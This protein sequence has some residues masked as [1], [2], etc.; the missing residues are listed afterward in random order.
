MRQKRS[1]P[2]LRA[3][4]FAALAATALQ[5][6]ACMCDE[7]LNEVE[8]GFT[9]EPS[10]PNDVID[11]GEV[12]VGRER[13]R[14][15]RITNT[16]TVALTEFE[17]T[18]SERNATH[19][20]VTFPADFG[21][22]LNTS[23]ALS[24]VFAP[25]AESTNLG[26]SFTVA[27]P[28]VSGVS[29]GAYNVVVDGDGYAALTEDDAGV[30]DGG[31][32]DG[33]V[34]A[35]EDGGA[36][37]GGDGDGG[38]FIDAG[39]VTP[40]D[41]GVILGPN[42]EWEAKGALQEPRA[43]F[44]SV[45]LDDGSILSIGGFGA[46]GDARASIERFDPSTGLSL[47]VGHMVVPRVW[48]GAALMPSGKVA[49]VGGR[50]ALVD[51]IDLSTVEVFDP[52]NTDVATS[53]T[54]V[55]GQGECQLDDVIAGDGLLD[56][57]RTDPL[58]VAST[59]E[60]AVFVIFGRAVAF[61]METVVPEHFVVTLSDTPSAVSLGI[62]PTAR[63]G[64]A[65]I[66]LEDGRVVVAGGQDATGALFD[67]AW[68]IDPDAETV[69]DLGITVTPRTMGGGAALSTGDV[70]LVGGTGTNGALLTQVERIV[71]V[72]GTPAVEVLANPIVAGRI[73]PT[74]VALADDI[75]LV[76]GG[77]ASLPADA[78]D[79]VV[80][81]V[82]ADVLVPL[83]SGT[84]L[85]LSSSNQ[86]ATP[87]FMHQ[88]IASEDGARATF[89]GGTPTV[90]RMGAH[91]AIEH[92]DVVQNAFDGAGLLGPGS[93]YEVAAW[94]PGGGVLS[95]GGTDPHTGAITARNRLYDADADLHVELSPLGGPRRDHTVTRLGDDVVYLVAGG[96]DA[97]GQVLSSASLYVPLSADFDVALPVSLVRARAEHTST[98][99]DDGRVLLCGGKG[100]LGEPLDTCEIFTPP[101]ALQNPATYDTASFELVA[102][103]MSAG[104]YAHTSTLLDTGE[105]LLVGGGDVEVDLVRADL[106]DPT[107]TR[108]LETGVP[109][110]ARR[111]HAAIF[112]GSGR[113]LIVGGEVGIGGLGPTLTTEVY[114]RANGIFIPSG[115]MA[116]ARTG[117]AG[118]RLLDGQVLVVGGATFGSGAFPTQSLLLAELYTPDAFGTGT[119]ENIDIPLNT[120]R[121]DIVGLDVYG[122]AVVVA[123]TRR[124][125]VLS[126]GAERRTPLF[127]VERLMNPDP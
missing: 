21:I 14:T 59:S 99:L 116:T 22:D 58:V 16:G 76:A 60:D 96:R 88:T 70:L 33:G 4:L 73:G 29:C 45:L 122:R 89:I 41:A 87:R 44:A 49:I 31:D 55:S 40:P 105:V 54:C 36:P 62:G 90:P 100:A 124:D 26:S 106:F 109:T 93:A 82:S 103:R 118:F 43:G 20:R 98:L 9:V 126:S 50:S 37:D 48:P 104:R 79:G 56:S 63:T 66:P 102:G 1:M 117:A 67:D 111:G 119:F 108:V 61:G 74:V 72:L 85:R 115:E 51:G 107:E 19:Y 92:Y 12:E 27:H 15:I 83:P 123:G 71:D 5:P 42:A 75:V 97:S 47:V 113:V 35:G 112:L 30:P 53:V 64:E 8:C 81:L 77:T 28:A 114:E 2:S 46:A 78:T 17:I 65:R 95:S 23:E 34:D 57:G 6:V 7:P 120:A 10:G 69:T 125:A 39:I 84:I 13:A 11:F 68:I 3:P 86:L 101:T 32:G 127:F 25:L 18:F 80:P 91:A 94:T 38:V 121:S 52:A 24:V 110:L